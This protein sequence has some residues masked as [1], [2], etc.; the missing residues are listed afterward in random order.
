MKYHCNVKTV[1]ISLLVA[2]LFFVFSFLIILSL[3]LTSPTLL[4]TDKILSAVSSVDSNLS[5]EFDAMERNFR[6]RVM[7]RGFSLY[8]DKEE[9]LSFDKV[10]VKLGLFDI[11]KYILGLEG[12]AEVNFNSGTISIPETFFKE[13]MEVDSSNEDNLIITDTLS[14][15]LS[16]HTLTLSFDNT[17]IKSEYAEVYNSSLY[18]S[19]IGSDDT[20]IGEVSTPLV[21]STFNGYEGSLLNTNISFSLKND[22]FLNVDIGSVNIK[23]GDEYIT[24]SKIGLSSNLSLDEISSNNIIAKIDIDSIKGLFYDVD[25]NA[26]KMEVIVNKNVIDFTLNNAN[27]SYNG[28]NFALDSISGNCLSFDDIALSVN[29]LN[30]SISSLSLDGIGLNANIA[31]SDKKVSFNLGSLYSNLT[32]VTNNVLKSITLSSLGGGLSLGDKTEIN[33]SLDS[34]LKTSNRDLSDITFSF[35]GEAEL[36][37]SGL[38]NSKIEI[39]N[40]YLGYGEKYNSLLSLS[41]NLDSL[42]FNLKY[43]NIIDASLTASI[44]E[45]TLEGSVNLNS[46]SLEKILPLFTKDKINLFNEKSLV[47]SNINFAFT[48]NSDSS[49]GLLGVLDYSL[50][51]SSFNIAGLESSFSSSALLKVENDKVNISNL[52]VATSFFTAHF[53]GY[54]DINMMLP[55]LDFS[56]KGSNDK[57]YFNGFIHLSEDQYYSFYGNFPQLTKTSLFGEVDFSKENIVSSISTLETKSGNRPFSLLVD[58]LNKEITIRSKSLSVDVDYKEGINGLISFDNL[59]TLSNTTNDSSIVCNG[60]I[61]FSFLLDEGFNINSDNFE[62][63][64]IFLLPLSPTI[65][66]ALSGNDNLITLSNLEVK[67]ENSVMYTG[68]LSCDLSSLVFA[69]N[70][71]EYSGDGNLILSLY[72]EDDIVGVVKAEKIDLTSLGLEKMYANFNLFGSAKKIEDFSFY[73]NL[74]VLSSDKNNDDREINAKIE[75]TSDKLSITDILYNSDGVSLSIDDIYLSAKEGK[76]GIING[77]GLIENEHYDR[78]Y[79]I[80]L[81]FALSGEIEK[82]E[83]LFS[84]V[85]SLIE[86]K[87]SGT[88]FTFNLSSLDIDNGTLALS[89]KNF[90]LS[91]NEDGLSINGNL[92]KGSVDDKNKKANLNVNL[93]NILISTFDIDYS[94]SLAIHADIDAFNMGLINLISLY[95]TLVFRDDLIYGDALIEKNGNEY[96]MSG[97]LNA[98]EL[99]VDVFWLDN[100]T[101]IL[102]NP[103]FTLWDNELRS[104]IGSATVLDK[105]TL[106]RKSIDMAVEVNLTPTLSIE[107]YVADIYIDDNNSVR[108]R[109]PL[110]QANIDISGNVTGHYKMTINEITM[111]NEGDIYVSDATVSVGMN[112]YPAWYDNLTGGADVDM[113]VNFLRNNRI[114]YP[115]GDDP[116][117]TITLAENSH[118][119]A[120]MDSSTMSINGDIN[121]RG[122][123]IFYFQKYFY[124]TS[125]SIV[126]DDPNT[127]NPKISLRATLRDYDSSSERVEIYLV[128]KDNTFNN[129]SPTLESSPAK[130][131]SEIMEILGQSILPQSAYGSVSVGSV[132][133]IV[134]EGFDILSRLGIVTT[135]S[136][137][138]SSLSASLK[139]LFGVDSFSLHSNIINNIL[140]DTISSVSSSNIGTFSPMA[141][142]LNGTT[143][144]VGKYLSQNLYLQF[145]VHLEA[146]NAK[147]NYTIISDDLA[148]DTELSLEWSNDAFNVTFFT[149]PSYFSLYSIVDTFGFSISKTFNL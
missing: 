58:L 139:N 83:S 72:K 26:K 37:G 93:E 67:S 61:S 87:G 21:Y 60:D 147:N 62:V 119:S 10:E 123:E 3:N 109:L 92:L 96:R 74:A 112:P 14:E 84:S 24:L 69:L 56:V 126:F 22:L 12:N 48:K 43:G 27:G 19:Y 125:G 70:L 115:A 129:I 122:G 45:E 137:P 36:N 46:L 11:A 39:A 131:L 138:L 90:T 23:N 9:I 110:P 149:R 77:H 103:R 7:I 120:Y 30:Y 5:F 15:F 116:I 79:P 80:E 34:T 145:M 148:L 49:L 91:I 16:N 28:S 107:S 38:E 31:L 1:F 140:S 104:S 41:G 51:L 117:F 6:D 105:S 113:T 25:F 50:S 47:D 111:L 33:L 20:L 44:K 32:N 29:K 76:F 100:Q 78:S 106:E 59:N 55:Y 114:L 66:F 118:V 89:D 75:L 94:S 4:V 57:P 133:S 17:T 130:E 124:I 141:R 99:A 108:V 54:Y 63:K 121:I 65:S 86:T 52:E 144:N 132:A 88:S 135:A 53:D 42:T 128:M 102:H 146:S 73:G 134:T 18:F 97:N 35:N 8:Y 142:F 127:F 98:K 64:N 2:L 68:L 40:L 71:K 143:L 136:N 85:V 101:V 81:G 13:N 95:P 82:K